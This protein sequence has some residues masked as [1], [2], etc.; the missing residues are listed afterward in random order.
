MIDVCQE[1]PVRL[2]NSKHYNLQGVG[3]PYFGNCIVVPNVDYNAYKKG[4]MG[5]SN[6]VEIIKEVLNPSTGELD[7]L[8]ILPLIRCNENIACELN[9]DIY[10][11]C[12]THF[13]KDVRTYQFKNI[14]L[15]GDTGKR[16]LNCNITDYLDTLFISTNKRFYNIN[17]SPFIKYVNEDKFEIFKKYLLK[18]KNWCSRNTSYKQKL[19]L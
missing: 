7:D 3:N 10:N 15:L 13:I 14:L 4:N 18:W 9:K 6:Q 12:L 16:F 11:R 5:F 8:Y 2:F 1:C 17:Y 19:Y